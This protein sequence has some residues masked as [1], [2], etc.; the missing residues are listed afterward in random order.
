MDEELH[1]VVNAGLLS[2]Q[3]RR[4][5]R[6]SSLCRQQVQPEDPE[7]RPLA[8]LNSPQSVSLAGHQTICPVTDLK[9]AQTPGQVQ[10]RWLGGKTKGAPA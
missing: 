10:T 5:H 2:F 7:S 9:G 3:T 6:V 8:P 1:H 4:G